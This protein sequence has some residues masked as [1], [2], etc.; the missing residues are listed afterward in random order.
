M[1]LMYPVS[2]CNMLEYFFRRLGNRDGRVSTGWVGLQHI[3]QY[4]WLT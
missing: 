4:L 2:R 1:T 3:N